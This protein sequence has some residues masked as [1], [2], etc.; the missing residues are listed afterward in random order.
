MKEIKN[1]NDLKTIK[2]LDEIKFDY[3]YELRGEVKNSNHKGKFAG[4]FETNGINY[5]VSSIIRPTKNIPCNFISSGLYHFENEKIVSDYHAI[6]GLSYI[7]DLE[8]EL[9]RHFE[10]LEEGEKVPK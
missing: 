1:V 10:I 9:K 6:T 3:S 8:K 5:F 2:K 4:Y 7:L